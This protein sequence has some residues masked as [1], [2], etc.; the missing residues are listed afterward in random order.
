MNPVK[1]EITKVTKRIHNAVILNDVNLSFESGKVYGLFGPNGSGKTMLLRL[2]AGLILPTTGTVSFDGKIMGK[3]MDFYGSMGVLIE[4][5]AFLP[6]FTGLQ[7]L[8]LLSQIQQRVDKNAIT[9][10]LKE[11][12]LDPDD[13]RKFGKYSLGMKQRLGIAATVMEKPDIILLDEPTNALDCDGISEICTLIQREKERGALIL[14]A[15]HQTEVLESVC[16]EVIQVSEGK[17]Q[18][19]VLI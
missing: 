5:P 18:K 8:W 7:N 9:Q 12:G 4:T 16:D 17:F 1:V 2:I 11:V 10:V 15:S 14:L 3:D 6:R 19:K 13:K